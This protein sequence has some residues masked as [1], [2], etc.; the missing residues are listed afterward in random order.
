MNREQLKSE[1][2][3]RPESSSNPSIHIQP[4]GGEFRQHGEN[5]SLF[6]AAGLCFI[7]NKGAAELSGSAGGCRCQGP[8][9]FGCYGK[10]LEWPVWT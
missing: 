2:P 3:V 1:L 6:F 4:A 9:L 7:L 10:L 5:T 8:R